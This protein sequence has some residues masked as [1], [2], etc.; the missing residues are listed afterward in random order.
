MCGFLLAFAAV[1][2]PLSAGG[3][4][5]RGPL[6]ASNDERLDL[7]VDPDVAYR[8]V[9]SNP[10]PVV[11]SPS[12][13]PGLG[14]QQSNNNLSIAL[15][16]GRL[17]LAFRNAPLHFASAK[18][19][20]IVLSSP[21]LGRTWVYETSFATGR[22]LREP[23]LLEVDGRL[24]LYYAELGDHAYT[25]EPLALWRSSRCGPRCW[26]AAEK[27]GGPGEIAWDFKV[28]A[29]RAWMTSYRG[30]HY[31]LG[32][33]SIDIRF[34]SSVD[35]LAWQ[36]VGSGSVYRG[37]ATE[38]SFEFD[39]R[40]ALWAIT[41]NEDGDATGFGSQV[42]SAEP[43]APGS[44][45]FPAHSNPSRFDSPRLFR[46]G[47][48]IYLLARRDLGPPAGARFPSLSGEFRKLL[49][50]ASYSLQ[51]KRTALY[52]LDPASRRFD[53]VCDLPSAGDTAFP[54]IV[55]LSA[56]EFL[57][58]NYSSAF[59]HADR[60]WIWGQLNGTGIYFVR[61]RFEP[62]ATRGRPGPAATTVAQ[63]SE[64]GLA[65]GAGAH[66][67]AFD[68]DWPR[69]E[70]LRGRLAGVGAISIGAFAILRRRRR[71]ASLRGPNSN[72]R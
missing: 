13:P 60:S 66:T 31:D 49:V 11:P 45:R 43:G 7:Q 71:L 29:G 62:V 36:D 41:R 1:A 28:R 53:L 30:K 3:V 56:H 39:R 14:L 47:Q 72:G 23:F 40:G 24:L 55:R 26:T 2:R 46:H 54:S 34:R 70:R 63:A 33:P 61:L 42:A 21:D 12:L 38:A 17:F 65:T 4:E 22:D 48:Q 8:A 67:T 10:V 16:Q 6:T 9:L 50:W 59:H 57:I 19:R 52:R 15:H 58:A 18:A 64:A 20:L 69:P 44:W 27:W 5:P 35:G 51:P 37:G 25:F 68:E 32:T